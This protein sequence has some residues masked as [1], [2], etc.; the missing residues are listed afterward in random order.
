M[1]DRGVGRRAVL[2]AGAAVPLAALPGA[3]PAR[4]QQGWP[5]KP[6]RI[7]SGGAPGGG[8]DIF[9]RI[10]E[11][12]LRERL[13]QNLYID[14]KPGAG[15]MVAAEIVA[16]AAPDGHTYFVSNLAT[17]GIG[18][19]LYRRVPFDP[20]TDLPGVA[21]IATF[22]NV[23]AVRADRGIGSVA[24]LIAYCRANPDKA[25]FG[26]AGSGTSSHLSGVLF[27]Q[28]TGLTLTH[29][30]YRGTAANLAALLAGEVLFCLDNLPVYSPHARTGTLTL[31]AV[32]VAQRLRSLPEVPTLQESGVAEFDV[33]SWY[34][35][36]AAT[37]TPR[38]II[39][40]L[41]TEV[42]TALADPDIAARIR[43]IG[44]EPAPLGPADYDAF[45]RAEVR[46]WEP[47]IRASGAT[48]D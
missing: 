29:V 6:I 40:R 43:D 38:P 12:R 9:V 30:P 37:G 1:T 44:S 21:R 23:L 3:I 32:S 14:N 34:G 27:G 28:R 2:R 16:R 22:S 48:V 15:G 19:T 25:Y 26:S 41:G 46:K 20:V 17:N 36:S 11:T 35:L 24:E 8:S 7:V 4:A 31:L 39:E 42:V 33:S 45:I 13:G 47:A 18:V 10:L 5:S